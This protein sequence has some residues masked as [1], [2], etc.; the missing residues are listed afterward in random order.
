VRR[1]SGFLA[2]RLRGMATMPGWNTPE[3]RAAQVDHR[4]AAVEADRAHR[5]E[6]VRSEYQRCEGAWQMP[7]SRAVRREV[8]HLLSQALAPSA[9]AAGDMPDELPALDSPQ[10]LTETE[11]R[12]MRRAAAAELMSGETALIGMAMQWWGRQVAERIYGAD[13]VHRARLLDRTTS[14]TV[15]APQRGYL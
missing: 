11:V 7:R 14:L 15:L 13:L 4:D 10:A 2:D 3:Q 12:Q 6:Q 5:I 8:D 9:P 1:P